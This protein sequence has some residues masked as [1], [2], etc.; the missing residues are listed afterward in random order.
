MWDNEDFKLI[1]NGELAK[2]QK[3]DLIGHKNI[4]YIM[5]Y[6]VESDISHSAFSN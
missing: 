5:K 4:S 1:M 2:I 3:H 6:F